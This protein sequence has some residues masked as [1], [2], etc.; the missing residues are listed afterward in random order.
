MQDIFEGEVRDYRFTTSF[1]AA[2]N[3]LCPC[4]HTL[5]NVFLIL[6]SYIVS[7]PLVHVCAY[8]EMQKEKADARLYARPI[9]HE[10]D[11]SSE[12]E[13]RHKQRPT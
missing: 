5:R 10:H 13:H 1:D 9:Q 3:V 8:L 12:S 2:A 4:T 11:H 6:V 7:L